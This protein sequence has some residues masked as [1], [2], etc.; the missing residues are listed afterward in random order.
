MRVF[1]VDH[2]PTNI[3]D[4]CNQIVHFEDNAAVIQTIHKDEDQI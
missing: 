4:K 1:D 3:L 2:D